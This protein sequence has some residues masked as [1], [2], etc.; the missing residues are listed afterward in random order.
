MLEENDPHSACER[1]A[2]GGVFKTGGENLA[3]TFAFEVGHD[4]MTSNDL[5]GCSRSTNAGKIGRGQ[6]I[7]YGIGSGNVGY[8]LLKKAGWEEGEGLGPDGK[9]RHV[10]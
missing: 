9:V 1:S 10:P 3:R 5:T 4:F 6:V 8:K 2:E 7:K